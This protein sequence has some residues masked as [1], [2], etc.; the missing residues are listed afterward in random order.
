MP[1]SSPMPSRIALQRKLAEQIHFLGRMIA[2]PRGV[3]AVLPSSHFLASAMVAQIDINRPGP[4][5]ELGPGSGSMTR[6]MLFRGIDPKRLT[7]VERDG[8]FVEKIIERF[9]GVNVIHGDALNLEAT[10]GDSF[11]QPFSAIVSGI[12]LLNFPHKARQDM[13]EYALSRLALGAPFIQ[14]SYGLHSPIKT[15]ANSSVECA[16]FVF[17]NVPPARVWVYRRTR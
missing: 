6:R 3:G 1:M 4:I 5:L 11:T 8:E 9:P 17:R 12:P 7:V 10:L 14:F 16:A 2:S 15:P 13:A